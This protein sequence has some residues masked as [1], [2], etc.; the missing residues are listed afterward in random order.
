MG[1]LVFSIIR[2]THSLLHGDGKPFEH[3]S[4]TL[5]ERRVD[6]MHP[7][8]E[9]MARVYPKLGENYA[10]C[11]KREMA[12]P[13]VHKRRSQLSSPALLMESVRFYKRALDSLE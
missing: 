6:F 5:R 9:Q 7:S 11:T 1:N 13:L 12:P 4:V 3:F 10:R 2:E 8:R